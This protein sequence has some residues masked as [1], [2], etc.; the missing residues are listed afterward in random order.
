MHR[1]VFTPAAIKTIRELASEGKTAPEIAH[2]IGSTPASVRVKCCQLKISLARRG[3]P[4][5]APKLSPS[6]ERQKLMLQV[7]LTDYSALKQKAAQMQK[8]TPE[9]VEML[10]HAIVRSAIYESILD[11]AK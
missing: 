5:S 6:I 11:K 9:F 2:F 4:T 3:R 8:S 10:L 1:R 7:R